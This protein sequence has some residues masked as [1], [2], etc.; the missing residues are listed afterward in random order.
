MTVKR[1]LLILSAFFMLVAC[2]EK[3]Q[4][5]EQSVESSIGEVVLADAAGASVSFDV[6]TDAPWALSVAGADFEVTPSKGNTGTTTITVRAS[7]RNKGTS[8]LPVGTVTIRCGATQHEIPVVQKR[9][10]EAPQ[11]VI[12]Y[13]PW[14]GNLY[15]YFLRNIEDASKAVGTDILQESRLL[16]FLQTNP[17]EGSLRELYYDGER[18][19]EITIATY[20]DLDVTREEQIT[21]LFSQMIEEA[22]AAQYGLVIGSHGMAWIPDTNS[23]M[24][25]SGVVDREKP[26]WEYVS[27]EGAF[28]RWFGDG[29]TRS[30]NTTTFARAIEQT[31]VRFEYILFDDCFM[32]SIEATY[33]LRR[34]TRHIIASPCEVMAYGYPYDLVVPQ[35]FV[36]HG[37]DYDLLGICEA[38]YNFYRTYQ[39][40]HGAIAVTVCDELERMAEVM[41]EVN[42]SVPA[43]IPDPSKPLKQYEY[44]YN[45]TRFYD[46]GDY[47]DKLC[48]DNP[49][50]LSAFKTQLDHTVPAQYRL[51]TGSFY[52]G[53]PRRIDDS[54]YWGISTSAPSTSSVVTAYIEDTAWHVATH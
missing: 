2:K 48:A 19:K 53:G 51:H 44:R 26:H 11:T 14:S 22:P 1:F 49:S 5:T 34:A 33:D 18:C 39:Y 35:L 38:F 42:R 50:L 24:R 20:S 31:G 25:R 52:S 32:S 6:T 40:P 36:N 29:A 54:W 7:G 15:S 37:A 46:F 47:V 23:E 8:R 43:Y 10:S 4:L 13:L 12:M 30:T 16:I 3:I 27:P 45:P 21:E 41:R 28:T 9:A 17:T